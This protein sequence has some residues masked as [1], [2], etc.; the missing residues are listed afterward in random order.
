MKLVLR[1]ALL[2]LILLYSSCSSAPPELSYF[3]IYPVRVFLPSSGNY[4]YELFAVANVFS[5]GGLKSL[6]ELYIVHDSKQL[7]WVS[8]Q[9]EW[10][11]VDIHG[12]HWI[13]VG[14]LI[15]GDM[16]SPVGTYRAILV[17]VAGAQVERT[18]TVPSVPRS[19]GLQPEIEVGDAFFEIDSVHGRHRVMVESASGELLYEEETEKTRFTADDFA[20]NDSDVFRVTVSTAQP[21]SGYLFRTG[22]VEIR[23]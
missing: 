16:D 19:R 10:D 13:G 2:S 14:G 22:P 12:E 23:L 18:Y 6:S 20:L 15:A 7:Y 11:P 8:R 1:L 9:E 5:E 17:D 4:H 21:K 3:E